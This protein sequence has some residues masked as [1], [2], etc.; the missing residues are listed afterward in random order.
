MAQPQASA[1]AAA[2]AV[3]FD[4]PA[5]PLDDALL[6]FGRQAGVQLMYDAPTVRGKTVRALRGRH[7]PAD[8]LARLL[9]GQGVS[10]TQVR[11]DAFVLQPSV[12][13][14][15]A[16]IDDVLQPATELAELVVTGTLIRGAPP[17]SP[18]LTIG[19]DDMDRSGQATVADLLASLPQN[20][21]G[22]GT[23]E[24]TL[25][26]TDG[27]GTNGSMNKGVNLRGLGT[28]S[29]L[30]LVNGRRM[31]GVGLK[32]DFADVSA[33]PTVA[34]QRVEVLLDGA[35]AIYG[36]DAVGGVVN[37]IPRRD[38]SGAES[39]IRI[40]GAKGGAEQLQVSH[41][42]GRHWDGGHALIAYEHQKDGELASSARAFTA[43]TDLRALGGTDRRLIYSHPGNIVAYSAAAGAYVPTYAIPIG[44][45]GVGLTP[46]DFVAGSRNLENQRLGTSIL[47]QQTRHSL[48]LDLEQRVAPSVTISGDARYTSRRYT[49][50]SPGA[51]TIFSVGSANPYFVSPTGKTSE[52]IGYSFTDELGAVRSRGRSESLG[53]S[54]AA[55]ID[56]PRDWRADNYLAFAQERGV[57]R[58]RDVL[59]TG[60]LAEALGNAA[61]DPTTS[62]VAARDGYFNPFGDGQANSATVLDFI[63]SGHET[64]RN[65]SQVASANFKAD[66]DLLRLPGGALKAAIGAQF[67]Q[68]KFRTNLVSYTDG[69]TPYMSGGRTF[70]RNVAAAFV[71]LRA[72]LVGP[73]NARLGLQ[74]L[75]LSLAGR[76]EAY[77]EAGSSA[78]PK[79]GVLWSPTRGLSLRATYGES[80]RAPALTEI[81]EAEVIAP[82][83]LNGGSGTVLSLIQY[84]GNTD[85]KPETAKSWTVGFDYT[86]PQLPGVSF[87]ATAF[88][89]RY[90]NRI[91]RPVIESIAKAL[92]DPTLSA[93]ATRIN[94]AAN[95]ADLARLQALIDR[96]TISS[97][98][99]FP[100][101][102]YGAIVDARVVNAAELHVAGFDAG[103]NWSLTRGS[104]RFTAS[105]N[106]TY[107]AD[108]ERKLT[109]TAPVVE[110]VDT[111]G[112]PVD[113]RLRAQTG[114]TRGAIGA[115]LGVNYVD[116]YDAGAGKTVK[117]WTTIDLQLTW[118]SQ[119]VS[120]PTKGLTLAATAQ[121]LLDED[122]PFYDAPQGVGYDPANADPLGRFLAVQ[123]TKRW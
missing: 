48:Y 120:G 95:A 93:F 33:I 100:A 15:A 3:V 94:P 97:V 71:E 91:G 112:Q 113:L 56:L 77:E 58:T 19:R 109:P 18:V 39:R 24:T 85:L 27:A 74:R 66:G 26:L 84:G 122:P 62:Y 52:L 49:F 103:V 87:N 30:V 36:S 13:T 104:D 89:V 88:D 76:V 105:L 78:T 42:L 16:S 50:S 108:Y 92:T 34:V 22:G 82:G 20:F 8:A 90:R 25:A 5:G 23:P 101:T 80:F 60:F 59:N 40:G 45:N 79:L 99:L 43:T 114:W 102:A 107:L 47:P 55:T 4:I 44:Q 9:A 110:L 31:A 1:P 81:N 6:K 106:A 28:T 61:D 10:S 98:K 53:V 75:E 63:G 46:A 17:S 119:A 12:A 96:S 2:K 41:I 35:S 83:Y 68:E 86:P 65:F 32:G 115:N 72:P 70:K 121:N 21:G 64:T 117:A 118:A 116:D 69:T 29:T 38:F 37:I 111:A 67:R 123:L 57:R 11:P 7:R 54:L 14:P 51:S 73:D